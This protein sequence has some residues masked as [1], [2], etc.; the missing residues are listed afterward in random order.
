MLYK[1]KEEDVR[2]NYKYD[3]GETVPNIKSNFTDLVFSMGR[4]QI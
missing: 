2:P 4:K 3:T 1:E